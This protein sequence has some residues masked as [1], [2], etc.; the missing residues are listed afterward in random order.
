MSELDVPLPFYTYDT[1]DLNLAQS[2]SKNRYNNDDKTRKSKNKHSLRRKFTSSCVTVCGKMQNPNED[3]Q[4][5]DILRAKGI[6]PPKDNEL[7]LEEDTVVQVSL[8]SSKIIIIHLIFRGCG[9]G[10]T[11]KKF[12]HVMGQSTAINFSVP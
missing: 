5:N 3:T 7:T 9:L 1:N 6:L 4:W 12:Y 10:Y 8:R 2:L 11:E